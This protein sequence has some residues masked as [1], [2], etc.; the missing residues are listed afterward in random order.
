[1]QFIPTVSTVSLAI[2]PIHQN[3]ATHRAEAAVAAG[4]CPQPYNWAL[5]IADV[6]EE[7]LHRRDTFFISLIRSVGNRQLPPINYLESV[8]FHS[9]AKLLGLD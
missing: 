5:K 6:C 4:Q 9:T 2:I 1:M 3:G 7:V 8:I